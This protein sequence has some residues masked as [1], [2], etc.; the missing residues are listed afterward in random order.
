LFA[1]FSFF[2]AGEAVGTKHPR[3]LMMHKNSFYRTEN[4]VLFLPP[5]PNFTIMRSMVFA[6]K[7][8]THP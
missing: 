8:G 2:K 1:D 6:G 4:R 7:G 3:Q 5:N